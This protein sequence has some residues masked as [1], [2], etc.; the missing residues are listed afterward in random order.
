MQQ[1]GKDLSS[2]NG[3]IYNQNGIILVGGCFDLLYPGHLYLL[4]MAKQLGGKL[5]VAVLSDKYIKSYKGDKRPAQHETTRLELIQSLQCVDYAIL[6]DQDPYGL[7]FLS[8]IKPKAIIIGLET[9]KE[10]KK[11][12]KA[13]FLKNKIPNLEI[14]FLGRIKP[15]DFSTTAIIQKIKDL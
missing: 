3:P 12:N 2:I 5:L 11:Q 4:K 14:F 8:K 10:L 6:V 1:Y 13:E 7:C 15:A 9:E